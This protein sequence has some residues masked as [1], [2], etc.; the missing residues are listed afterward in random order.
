[1]SRAYHERMNLRCDANNPH[2]ARRLAEWLKERE[3]ERRAQ[4]DPV[5]RPLRRRR[6]R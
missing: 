4:P 1:M 5:K 6:P 3:E 2:H